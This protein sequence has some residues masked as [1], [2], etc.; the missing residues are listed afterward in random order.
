MFLVFKQKELYKRNKI[1]INLIIGQNQF[2]VFLFYASQLII[3]RFEKNGLIILF[4][5]L[6]I[7]QSHPAYMYLY[8]N[9]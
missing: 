6:L 2:Q 3:F 5:S 8:S 9:I 4:K 1:S 7:D